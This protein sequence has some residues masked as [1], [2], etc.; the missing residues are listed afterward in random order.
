MEFG[1]A[2]TNKMLDDSVEGKI[3]SEF[4]QL[5]EANVYQLD[6]HSTAAIDVPTIPRPAPPIDFSHDDHPV[7]NRA[8]GR[9][10]AGAIFASKTPNTFFPQS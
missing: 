9:L 3:L 4:T 2:K 1:R 8:D 7:P 6:T 5:L 10:M